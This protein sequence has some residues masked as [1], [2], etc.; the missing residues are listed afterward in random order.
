MICGASRI[1][2]VT[3]KPAPEGLREVQAIKP[4]SVSPWTPRKSYGMTIP[5]GHWEAPDRSRMPV[6]LQTCVGSN[7]TI[8]VFASRE[9]CAD[10]L[11]PGSPSRTQTSAVVGMTTLGDELLKITDVA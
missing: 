11:Q 8:S 2:A 10:D 9:T 7:G 1:V 6:P 4:R 3:W 5:V